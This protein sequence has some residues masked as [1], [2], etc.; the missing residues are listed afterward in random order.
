MV[1]PPED[2]STCPYLEICKS[3]CPGFHPDRGPWV[4]VKGFIRKEEGVLCLDW[5]V[6]VPF[7]S[8]DEL[9]TPEG[10]HIA[11]AVEAADK[12]D[13][14]RR[15][16]GRSPKRKE[17]QRK[18]LGSDKGKATTERFQSSEKFRLAQQKYYHSRKGQEAHKKNRQ[19]VQSFREAERWLKSHPGKTFEDFFRSKEVT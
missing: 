9:R 10:R 5:N 18:Y 2:R 1:S 17:A 3:D 19:R 16:W 11:D 13:Q 14:S 4:P 15:R 6:L 12:I 7:S 8:F